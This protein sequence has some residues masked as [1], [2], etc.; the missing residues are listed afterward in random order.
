MRY[1]FVLIALILNGCASSIITTESSEST[2]LGDVS[3]Y[4]LASCYA[5]QDEPYLKDQGDA[6][7][8]VII[9]RMKGDPSRLLSLVEVI[10]QQIDKKSMA[11]MRSELEPEQ[12]KRLP[13]LY[14]N[15]IVHSTEVEAEIIDS[16]RKLESAY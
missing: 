12:D 1:P 4:A 11:V 3:D 10:K 7:A 13:V 16:S 6:W 14:C 8:S 2:V 5:F 9:Q 15:D